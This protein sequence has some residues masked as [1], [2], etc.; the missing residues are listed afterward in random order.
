DFLNRIPLHRLPLPEAAELQNLGIKTV[1]ELNRLPLP[2][3]ISHFGAR[4]EALARLGRGED[5]TP[6]Q[7]QPILDF[8][9]ELDCTVLE[10]FF[11]PLTT[12][13]LKPY[14]ERGAQRLADSLKEHNRAANLLELKAVLPS[15]TALHS[16]RKFKKATNEPQ[17]LKRAAEDII[18]KEPLA[19][20]SLVVSELETSLPEQLNMFVAAD[21]PRL[22]PAGLPAQRGVEVTRRERFLLLWKEYFHYE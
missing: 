17:V 22:P 19:R 3:L 1:G 18:P 16:R 2:E 7:T 12:Q 11:R 10:G 15:Q 6:F 20:L 14:I 8:K 9:W 5:L 21:I 4:A 13:E